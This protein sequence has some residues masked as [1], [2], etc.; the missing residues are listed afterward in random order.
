[1][2]FIKLF[3]LAVIFFLVIL[4]FTGLNEVGIKINDN[5]N[6][7]NQSKTLITNLNSDLDTNFDNLAVNLSINGSNE[8]QDP[9]AL[10]FLET[11]QQTSGLSQVVNSII[12]IPDLLLLSLID[13][14]T[15]EGITWVKIILAAF[16]V[17]LLFVAAFN[18]I[19]GDGRIT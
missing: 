13:G 18:G 6:L 8:G 1:M 16:I 7:D 12:S 11:K 3:P 15:E 14:L 17:I 19:F 4:I 9:F 5:S 10:Q 2:S